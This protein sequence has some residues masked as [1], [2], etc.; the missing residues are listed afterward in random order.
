MISS[1]NPPFV[2]LGVNLLRKYLT[3]L[4]DQEILILNNKE[5]YDELV[6]LFFNECL[7]DMELKVIIL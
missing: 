3:K 6:N 1:K 2:K 5:I 7:K 4:S